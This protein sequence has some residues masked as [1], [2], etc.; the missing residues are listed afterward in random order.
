MGAPNAH[1]KDRA[2]ME[3]GLGGRR[4][5]TTHRK[6]LQQAAAPELVNT[7]FCAEVPDQLWVADIAYVRSR[8]GFLYLAFILDAYSRK[9]VGWSMATHL[10]SELV[11]RQG[12]A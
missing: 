10:R 11:G 12:R 4:M 3:L 1:H 8:E 7:N 6:A 5:R 9:I 2:P